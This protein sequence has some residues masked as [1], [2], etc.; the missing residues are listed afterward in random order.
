MLSHGALFVYN[1]DGTASWLFKWHLIQAY[2]ITVFN[3][4]TMNKYGIQLQKDIHQQIAAS[5]SASTIKNTIDAFV[6]WLASCWNGMNHQK[7]SFA[8]L[9]IL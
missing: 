6:A 2:T 3:G 5:V 4:E 9:F 7:L 1:G 8:C